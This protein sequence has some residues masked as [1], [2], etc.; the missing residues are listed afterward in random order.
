MLPDVEPDPEPLPERNG[1]PPEGPPKRGGKKKKKTTNAE[2]QTNGDLLEVET[3]GIHPISRGE[4]EVVM[5]DADSPA[6]EEEYALVSTLNI[7]ASMDIQ[8]DKVAEITSG[9][10]TIKMDDSEAVIQKVAWSPYEDR[11]LVASG[12]SLLRLFVVP[13]SINPET[14]LEPLDVNLGL[15]RFDVT[16]FTWKGQ[17]DLIVAALEDTA[18]ES[19]DK[20]MLSGSLMR[21][22]NGGETVSAISEFEGL[23][24]C[25]KYNQASQRLLTVTANDQ[26]SIIKVWDFGGSGGTVVFH[27]PDVVVTATWMTD[28]KFILCGLNTLKVLEI[29]PSEIKVVKDIKAPTSS[30]PF[31]WDELRYDAVCDIIACASTETGKLGVV[32]GEQAEVTTIS[33]K[34]DHPISGLDFQPLANPAS[35]AADQP[36]L[37]ATSHEGGFVQLWDAKQPFQ[38]IHR[39]K[40][41]GRPAYAMAFSPDGFLLAAAGVDTVVI[42]NPEKGGAPKAIWKAHA[43]NEW[44]ATF[45]EQQDR[46]FGEHFLGWDKDGKKLAFT[47]GKQVCDGQRQRS[48]SMTDT[49]Q[50]AIINFQG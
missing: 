8:T 35:L 44:E 33:L 16:S 25:T 2:P 32:L 48:R 47:L 29:G 5:S 11:I 38:R 21:V 37:L 27:A 19:G 26:A 17:D 30:E 49:R 9:I 18:N 12:P 6:A 34:D 43:D 45:T 41:P 7:G 39:L 13:S 20:V 24:I 4:S 42:W 31:T 22:H 28:T 3:N 1:V 36:R 14:R 15:D 40:M 50:L 23:V 46:E 10:M